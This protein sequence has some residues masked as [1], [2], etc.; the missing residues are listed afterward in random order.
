[1][2]RRTFLATTGAATLAAPHLAAARSDRELIF[3]P[4][5]DLA[6]LD[7]VW[8]SATITRQHGYLVYD[9]LYGQDAE[10]RTQPQMVQ[11]HTVEQDGKLWRL[12]LREGLRFHDGEPVRA[13]DVVP[14]LKRWGRRDAFGSAML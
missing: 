8:T 11:G 5:A 13:Q 6:V 14:S 7:P 2:D 12:T 10:Y 1:M 4:Q 3:V 9:N